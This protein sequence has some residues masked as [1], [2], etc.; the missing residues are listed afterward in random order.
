MPLS[1]L[2]A[3][4]ADLDS[5]LLLMRQM[6]KDDPWAEPFD[7]LCVQNNLAEL[8]HDSRCGRQPGKSAPGRA[9][10][11]LPVMALTAHAMKGD[12]DRCMAAGMDGYLTKAIRRQELDEVL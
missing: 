9:V 10:A 7:E 5:L 6:Q 1:I 2:R 4:L 12:Q 3:T 11:H 8:L